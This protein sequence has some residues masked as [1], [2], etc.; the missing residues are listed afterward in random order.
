MTILTSTRLAE[1]CDCITLPTCTG[2]PVALSFS[3]ADFLLQ[4]LQHLRHPR[5]PRH[6][7][8]SKTGSL[9]LA[10]FTQS[11]C[12][13]AASTLPVVSA[14]SL[15]RHPS[16]GCPLF[17]LRWFSSR[18]YL[19]HCFSFKGPP[20]TRNQYTSIGPISHLIFRSRATSITTLRS[21]SV[22]EP[23]NQSL[24]NQVTTCRC[25]AGVCN[26]GAA[27]Y[28]SGRAAFGDSAALCVAECRRWD[29]VI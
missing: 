21:W 5:H 29:V 16:V 13:H 27:V 8:L 1:Q 23:S 4:R 22:A 20:G 18:W 15:V 12:L 26:C 7:Q 14:S 24:P 25:C 11:I 6:L 3:Y 28:M 19:S 2:I 10:C 9:Q 17:V